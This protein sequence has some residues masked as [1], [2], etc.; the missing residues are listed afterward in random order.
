MDVV[1]LS[2][3]EVIITSL[4]SFVLLSLVG[5]VVGSVPF[6]V[7][8]GVVVVPS[9]P[10]S[11]SFASALLDDVV[12]DNDDTTGCGCWFELSDD[13]VVIRSP[14]IELEEFVVDVV[15]DDAG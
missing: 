1:I 2:F 14:S 15:A 5:V 10:F 3:D 11:L 13:R 12:V 6:L 9:V 7:V 8:V 4:S